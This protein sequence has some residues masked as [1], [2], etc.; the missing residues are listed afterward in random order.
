L[1]ALERNCDALEQAR[2][3]SGASSI[4]AA[5]PVDVAPRERGSLVAFRASALHR[6]TPITRGR[7][8][9]LVVWA[10][11]PEFR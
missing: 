11:G 1:D 6:V 4:R 9:A 7:R 8:K 10:A 3:N 5:H 2:L